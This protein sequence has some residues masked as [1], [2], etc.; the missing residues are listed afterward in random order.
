M[1][2]TTQA[3]QP[4]PAPRR[5]VAL[6]SISAGISVANLYY[7]QPLL[8]A[9]ARSFGASERDTGL[10]PTATQLGYGLAMLVLVP[11]GDRYERRMLIVRMTWASVLALILVAIAPNLASLAAASLLLGIASMVPQYLVP[12][13]AGAAAAHERGQVVGTVMSGLLIGILLSRT[14]S[15]FVGAHFGWRV[16]YLVAAL[17]MAALS[18]V[19]RTGLP[20]Q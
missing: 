4:A 2:P 5:L 1:S 18:V 19:L 11:L 20:A 15:G 17:A 8:A 14:I 13:A 6:L 3:S 7:N 9:M 16:M 12:Y 10:I